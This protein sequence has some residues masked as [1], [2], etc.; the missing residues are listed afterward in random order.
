MLG[1]TNHCTNMELFQNRYR[2]ESVRL[3]G[4]DYTQPGVY[5]ITIV[6]HDR[7]CLFGE[8]VNGEM[9]L[10]KFGGL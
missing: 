5:F 4:H 2:V 3:Q 1:L 10:N 7:E 9:T 6:A 8:I